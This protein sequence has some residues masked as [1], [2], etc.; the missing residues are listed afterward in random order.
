MWKG[1]VSFGLVAIPIKLYAATEQHDVALHQVHIS[2]GGRVRYRR[3]CEAEDT[4]VPYHEIGKG[5]E[6]SKGEMV[7]LTDKELE[8][9]PLPTT[10]TIEVLQFVPQNQIDELYVAK[11]YYLEA[12]GPAAKPYVLLRDALA[13]S[14]TV[15]LVKIAIRRREALAVLRPRESLLV[16]HTMWWPDEVRETKEI[17]P[18][19]DV[20]ARKQELQMAASYIATLTGD[21][22]PEKFTDDY[23][24]ALNELVQ[25]KIEG[26]EVKMRAKKRQKSSNVIDLMA[27]LKEKAAGADKKSGTKR[28]TQAGRSTKHKAA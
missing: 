12:E 8:E 6:V 7:V 22:D 4:E 19:A 25:E 9:L 27:A 23:A 17:E 26:H 5:Y 24:K 20:T 10:D 16:M 14:E 1:V 13:Q 18:P 11:S 21:F 2:D 3:I 28:A 15:A